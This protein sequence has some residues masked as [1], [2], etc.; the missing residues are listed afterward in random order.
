M[1]GTFLLFILYM[2]ASIGVLVCVGLAVF[3][4]LRAQQEL[5]HPREFTEILKDPT[6]FLSAHYFSEEGDQYRLRFLQPLFVPAN[7]PT[8]R[9]DTPAGTS[10]RQ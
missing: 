7:K 9:K 1:F 6:L 10:R 4:L 3:F 8:G 2:V 5:K